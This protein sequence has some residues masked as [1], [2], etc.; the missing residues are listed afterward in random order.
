MINALEMYWILLTFDLPSAA[1]RS[2]VLMK[3]VQAI[4]FDTPIWCFWNCGY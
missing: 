2:M 4:A 3:H 1:D